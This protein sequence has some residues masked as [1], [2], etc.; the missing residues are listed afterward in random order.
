MWLSTQKHRLRQ[1]LNLTVK[2]RSEAPL[3][4]PESRSADPSSIFDCRALL[5]CTPR[6]D[7]AGLSSCTPCWM[8]SCHHSPEHCGHLEGTSCL[9]SGEHV[10]TTTLR[11]REA[12]RPLRAFNLLSCVHLPVSLSPYARFHCH[13]R[14]LK[15]WQAMQVKALSR[16]ARAANTK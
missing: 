12:R 16:A 11:G 15:D 5:M 13:L 4:P 1:V 2:M 7:T 6:G 9:S 3:G 10:T 8:A 14:P